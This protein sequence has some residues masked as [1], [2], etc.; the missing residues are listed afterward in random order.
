MTPRLSRWRAVPVA[1]LLLVL[2]CHAHVVQ[3]GFGPLVDT[4]VHMFIAPD[5][6]LCTIAAGLYCGMRSPV[7]AVHGRR[8]FCFAWFVFYLAGVALQYPFDFP[9]HAALSL[10]GAG[11]LVALDAPLPDHLVLVSSAWLG[12]LFGL[13]GG[14][15]TEGVQFSLVLVMGTLDFVVLL[16]LFSLAQWLPQRFP[17]ARVGYRVAGSW[18]T[19]VGML[20]FGWAVRMFLRTP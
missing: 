4:L 9:F 11:A 14:G 16:G 17:V 5:T 20:Q 3:T 1:A 15:T 13:I 8:L 10:L 7:L 6:A 19:A 18:I 12:G 2:P